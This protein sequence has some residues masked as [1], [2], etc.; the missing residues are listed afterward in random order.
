MSQLFSLLPQSS[1]LLIISEQ[2][3]WA[4][5]LL[6]ETR[7]FHSDLLSRPRNPSC[8][9]AFGW[10]LVLNTA[11]PELNWTWKLL[12]STLFGHKRKLF[13]KEEIS[14]QH[15]HGLWADS[16]FPQQLLTLPRTQQGPRR[17]WQ[18]R[19]GLSVSGFPSQFEEQL[20]RTCMEVY[21]FAQ[22]TAA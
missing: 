22:E 6:P 19:L 17:K 11:A 12:F 7:H 20:K 9:M 4:A 14:L 3:L 13:P 10:N 1:H 18:P 5:W 2:L 8:I 16:H 15:T 21:K